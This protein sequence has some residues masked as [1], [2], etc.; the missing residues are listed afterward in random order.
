MS[1]MKLVVVGAAGRM[2]QALIRA[3]AT[4]PGATVAAAI[5]RKG[6]PH[7][8]K[9]IGQIAG[10]GPIGVTV[11]DDP[12]PAFAKAD[13]VLDF[14]SP[15]ATVEFAGYAAQARIAHVIGTT[16]C[17]ANREPGRPIQTRRSSQATTPRASPVRRLTKIR[18]RSP[19]SYC[20]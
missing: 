8:G 1:E 5:E 11:S 4:I 16:G 6:S 15:A 17:S 3:I 20:S 14:T 10:I 13:G 19:A 18:S 12:L 2:G 7:L 9:D